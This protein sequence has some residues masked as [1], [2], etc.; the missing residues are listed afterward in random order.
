MIYNVIW[1]IRPIDQHIPYNDKGFLILKPKKEQ[2]PI[3]SLGYVSALQTLYFYF[4]KAIIWHHLT[5]ILSVNNKCTC[6]ILYIS[7]KEYENTF[8]HYLSYLLVISLLFISFWHH[9]K[10]RNFRQFDNSIK[11]ELSIS[12]CG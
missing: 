9:H 10:A 5:C 1:N 7:N 12:L 11:T 8:Y 4:F 6:N 3:K 2:E